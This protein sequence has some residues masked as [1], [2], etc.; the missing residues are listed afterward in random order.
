[1]SLQPVERWVPVHSD[2]LQDRD[3]KTVEKYERGA[4]GLG[5][6]AKVISGEES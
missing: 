4:W 3:D 6:S 1:M 2:A 5:A